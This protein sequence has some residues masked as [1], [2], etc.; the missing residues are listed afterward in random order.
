MMMMKMTA[1]HR[2]TSSILAMKFSG[3]L[4][5]RHTCTTVLAVRFTPSSNTSSH[6][7]YLTRDRERAV[8]VVR[9]VSLGSRV[10]EGR[11]T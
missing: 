10:M 3:E 1:Q 2:L 7:K 8:V 5:K 4:P 11:N 9:G 6:T